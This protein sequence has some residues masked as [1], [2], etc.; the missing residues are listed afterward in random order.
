MIS[1]QRPCGGSYDNALGG[2]P[3]RRSRSAR[4]EIDSSDQ[5]PDRAGPPEIELPP[6]ASPKTNTTI[7]D[8]PSL[9]CRER[10]YP[11][12]VLPTIVCNEWHYS[13]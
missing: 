8:T 7:R 6:F 12:P 9:P 1:G 13:R 4:Q 2:L 3:V 5:Q 10:C 11:I